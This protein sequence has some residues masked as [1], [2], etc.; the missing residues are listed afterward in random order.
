M[1][2]LESW[3]QFCTGLF[4]NSSIRLRLQELHSLSFGINVQCNYNIKGL[5]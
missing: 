4:G 5:G 1:G 3:V 2:F